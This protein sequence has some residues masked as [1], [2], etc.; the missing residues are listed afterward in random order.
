M[1]AT[2]HWIDAPGGKLHA[3]VTAVD[4]PLSVLLLHGASFNAET[5]RGLGTLDVLA[6]AGFGAIALDLPGFG[7]S[8]ATAADPKVLLLGA[9]AALGIRPPIVVAPSMSGRFAFPLIVHHPESAAGFVPV[10][11]VGI[12]EH[13]ERLSAVRLPVLIVWGDH[14]RVI[15]LNQADRLHRLLPQSRKLILLGARHPCYLDQ[16]AAF[17]AALIEFAGTTTERLDLSEI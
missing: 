11:P 15:P 8:P 3:L 1:T 4:A 5:W 14:D 17:H 16:P 12:A 6:D 13:A 10:A 7:K 2:S 9:I